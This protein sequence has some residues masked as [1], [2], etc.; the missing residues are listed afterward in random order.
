MVDVYITVT[1][2]ERSG[3]SN[4]RQLDWLFNI[5]SSWHKRN[6]QNSIAFVG[7]IRQWIYLAEGHWESVSVPWWRHHF[8]CTH[9][10]W[11]VVLW[12]DGGG[13]GWKTWHRVS[14]WCVG[15]T[16][17]KTQRH[18]YCR[19]DTT[20]TSTWLNKIDNIHFFL[21]VNT[22]IYFKTDIQKQM[23]HDTKR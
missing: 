18:F 9:Q 8:M 22:I 5:F 2:H 4:H 15:K 6:Q 7:G 1:S 20:K 19:E 13:G 14:R 10:Q 3:V 16:G 23:H 21:P 11:R 17:L 12:R